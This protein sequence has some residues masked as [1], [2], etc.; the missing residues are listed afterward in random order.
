MILSS[1]DTGEHDRACEEGHPGGRA[2][3]AEGQ[4]GETPGG[5]VCACVNRT[6]VLNHLLH[7]RH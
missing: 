2:A 3:A 4:R 1:A 7:C 6:D 5:S